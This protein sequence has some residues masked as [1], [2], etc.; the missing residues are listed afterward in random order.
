[1]VMS[2]VIEPA[3]SIR[4]T[5]GD[6]VYENRT[7]T[8]DDRVALTGS[9]QGECEDA[10]SSSSSIWAKMDLIV[11]PV[12]TM[13]FFLSSLVGLAGIEDFVN[14]LTIF[15]LAGSLQYRKCTSSRI[16]R[17]ARNHRRT[18]KILACTHQ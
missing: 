5:D 4:S 16:P 9:L 14:R 3:E 13:M 8:E 1:M 2:T 12:T 6:S 10:P 7:E 18:S 11:L 17:A 15:T